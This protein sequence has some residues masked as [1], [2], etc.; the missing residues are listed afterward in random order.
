[1]ADVRKIKT[2]L[3]ALALRFASAFPGNWFCRR[4]FLVF[5]HFAFCCNAF[6]VLLQCISCCNLPFLRLQCSAST[7]F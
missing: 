4:M 1:M 2:I 5:L 3:S 7:M 6:R